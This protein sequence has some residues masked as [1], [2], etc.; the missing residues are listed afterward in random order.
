MAKRYIEI[1]ELEDDNGNDKEVF[2]D[3]MYDNTYYSI[4]DEYKDKLNTQFQ[5]LE[6]RIEFLSTILIKKN[7]VQPNEARRDAR[8]MIVGKRRV[9]DGDFAALVIDNGSNDINEALNML[10]YKRINGVWILQKD[11][12]NDSFIDTKTKSVCNL[13]TDCIYDNKNKQ[14]DTMTQ[15]EIQLKNRVLTQSL[16]EFETNF[17][18][19]KT[20][21]RRKD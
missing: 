6:Q 17:L 1:D 20:K 19:R 9:E 16:N 11:I 2:F 18:K 3:K 12:S 14:C 7:G 4:V 10:Y 8:A 15:E 13:V 5:T 21:K